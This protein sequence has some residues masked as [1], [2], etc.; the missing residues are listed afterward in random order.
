MN[1]PNAAKLL[2]EKQTLL[3]QSEEEELKALQTA[4]HLSKINM[5]TIGH[6]D[7]GKST[8]MGHLLLKMGRVDK[9]TLH[10]YE[11]ES[12]EMGKVSFHFAWVLDEHQEERSRGITVD[13]GVNYFTTTKKYVTVLDAPGHKDF[14]PNMISGTAQA[15]VAILVIASVNGEFEAGFNGNGQTKE[16]AIL[17][18]SLGISQL[19]V[20]LNKMDQ[21]TPDA[22]CQK[23]YN[24]I[25]SQ[26]LPFLVSIGFD[27]KNIW[28]V[29]VSGLTGGNILVHGNNNTSK[30]SSSSSSNSSNSSSNKDSSLP[31][32]LKAWY[33]GP[34]LVELIDRFQAPK[35]NTEKPFRM[36]VSDVF[37][38]QSLGLA[39]SGKIEA[40]CVIP[41]E[42]ILIMPINV[43]IVVKGLEVQGEAIKI[44]K[45]GEK[46]DLGVK[47]I[48]DENFLIAGQIL[49]DISNPIRLVSKFVAQIS[50]VD[51]KIP[52]ISGTS[53]ILY[54]Q[55]SNE[56]GV[57]SKIVSLIKSSG[58]TLK[59]NPRAVPRQS[60]AIVEISLQRPICVETYSNM[61]ELG[62]ISIRK[63]GKTVAVGIVQ[64][65]IS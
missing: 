57:I 65:I 9:K 54:T 51:I 13:V 4:S 35:R 11:K 39:V 16:H 19:I 14:I 12:R 15:D 25:L 31:P 3:E 48:S 50:T 53:I 26:L 59:L 43:P 47:D 56:S 8:L 58:E 38:S 30:S 40:G 5:I 45:A 42:K 62:R 37:K 28:P 55:C 34:C 32:E 6:V 63:D 36:V 10:R 64:D 41:R 2:K 1:L 22:W 33:D 20:A 21:T 49:C 44:G 29:P 52:I 24:E 61:M 7:A 18:R 60:N 27:E 46:V 17:A 23:R